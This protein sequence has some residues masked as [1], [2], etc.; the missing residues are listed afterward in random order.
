M[1]HLYIYLLILLSIPLL[2]S[3]NSIDVIGV[4]WFAFSILNLSFIIYL[5]FVKL[6]LSPSFFFSFR[7]Y[8]FLAF[9]L[10]FCLL[11][12]FY[13]NNLDLSI[14]DLSR[15]INV[16]LS[17]FIFSNFYSKRLSFLIISS[18][19]SFFLIFDIFFAFK[20]FIDFTLN[21]TDSNFFSVFINNYDPSLLKGLCGNKNINAAYVLIKVPFLL[22]VISH[23]KNHIY[24][25]FLYLLLLASIILLFLLQARSAYVSLFVISILFSLH[26][27][28]Y[29]K[30][31]LFYVP[32]LLLGLFFSNLISSASS[33]QTI[34]SEITSI[35]LS[36]ESSSSR[37]KLWENALEAAPKSS[38]IGFGIG[39]W[40]IESLPY[41]NK[42]G[43][44]STVPYH[45]HNDFLELL[46]E[47]GL[48]GSLSYFFVFIFCFYF[49]F[50]NY[51]K[52]KNLIDMTIGC[53]LIIYFIDANLNFP[54]ERA[55]MQF[56]FSIILSLIFYR[57]VKNSI[58]FN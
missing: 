22:Y 20:P 24:R 34:T 46:T 43:S 21:N 42:N 5:F 41:W 18:F 35:K 6:V 17:I 28:F 27:F 31:E 26:A 39:N 15:I 3:D 49:I 44:A 25:I 47:I 33:S 19:I 36:N 2:P 29:S 45:A 53:S 1:K 38:F 10:F 13:S 8:L 52:T 23:L 37:F 50:S 7:P 58:Q 11:S 54:L 57:Y 40:K 51:I 12:L 4:H 48:L 56:F 16:L 9:F 55:T 32:I 30:K 14:V